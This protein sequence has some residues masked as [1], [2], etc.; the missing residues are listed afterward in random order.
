MAVFV[1][2]VTPLPLDVLGV[3]AGVLRFPF[4]KFFVACWCGKTLLYIG[5][6]LAGAWGWEAFVSGLLITSPISVGVSAALATLAL[7]VL[8]LFIE[9]WTWK[10][11]R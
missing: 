3:A 7:L 6:A 5:M 11:G 10:R 9:N 1:F 8:A 4:W 2:T